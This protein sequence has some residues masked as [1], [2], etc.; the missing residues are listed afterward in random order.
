MR[1][2][3]KKLSAFK[4]LRAFV[5]KIMDDFIQNLSL[6]KFCRLQDSE[7]SL[8]DRDEFVRLGSSG[9]STNH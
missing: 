2:F 9:R 5:I 4:L 6:G 1:V 3:K 7:K 8:W